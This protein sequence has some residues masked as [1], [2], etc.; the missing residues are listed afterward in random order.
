M[1]GKNGSADSSEEEAREGRVFTFTQQSSGISVKITYPEPICGSKYCAIEALGA[2]IADFLA[3]IEEVSD[4]DCSS[5]IYIINLLLQIPEEIIQGIK[6]EGEFGFEVD[7]RDE[8][9]QLPWVA[10]Q[11]PINLDV[12]SN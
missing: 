11:P 3:K 5:V 7:F 9:G 10:T 4:L 8:E 12:Y 6:E 1:S 2:N